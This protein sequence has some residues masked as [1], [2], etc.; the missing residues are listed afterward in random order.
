MKKALIEKE[1]TEKKLAAS[2]MIGE[3]DIKQINARI[4]QEKVKGT[5]NGRSQ[6]NSLTIIAQRDGIDHADRIPRFSIM[7]AQGQWNNRWTNKGRKC[8]FSG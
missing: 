8:S 3:K 5:V 7:G 6:V 1:K 2:K 4:I